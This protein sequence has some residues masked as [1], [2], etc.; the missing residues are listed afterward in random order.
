MY[1][2]CDLIISKLGWRITTARG[3][4]SVGFRVTECS[5]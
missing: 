4:I 3:A 2:H 5:I 1:K